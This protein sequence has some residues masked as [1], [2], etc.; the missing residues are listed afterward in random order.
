MEQT[1]N[2]SLYV[3]NVAEFLTVC[4][5]A[6][7]NVSIGM[8]RDW[9]YHNAINVGPLYVVGALQRNRSYTD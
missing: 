2:L 1:T 6:N 3:L 8:A 9:L 5:L 4:R 7:Q